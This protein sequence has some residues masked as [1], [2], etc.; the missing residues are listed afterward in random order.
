[1]ASYP[2]CYT[3]VFNTPI[4]V[5]STHSLQS[6]GKFRIKDFAV[7]WPIDT[8]SRV[9][10]DP[11]SNAYSLAKLLPWSSTQVFQLS[12]Q[13]ERKRAI[14]LNTGGQSQHDLTILFRYPKMKKIVFFFK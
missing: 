5:T 11:Y 13:R 10:L 4:L 12:A 2:H 6:S 9:L 1:M 3:S 7:L 8:L 14:V